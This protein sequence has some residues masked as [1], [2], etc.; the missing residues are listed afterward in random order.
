MKWFTNIWDRL[1]PPGPRFDFEVSYQVH[2]AEGHILVEGWVGKDDLGAA[3]EEIMRIAMNESEG[4]PCSVNVTS[5]YSHRLGRP[6]A[7]SMN[8]F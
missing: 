8:I 7:H 1:F 6:I 3:G 5:I 2:D 4:I